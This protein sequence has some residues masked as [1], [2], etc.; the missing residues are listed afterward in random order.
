MKIPTD[1]KIVC[2]TGSVWTGSRR[3]PRHMLV[4]DGFVRPVWF[5]TAH[6][7]NDAKYQHISETEFHIAKADGK[8]LA[9]IEYGGN[10]VGI[11][12]EALEAALSASQVGSLIVGPQDLVAGV[13]AKISS[14]IIF[15]LKDASMDLSPHLEDTERRGQLHR[16]DVDA[17]APGAWGDVYQEMSR[18]LGLEGQLD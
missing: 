7:I 3:A 13:A 12:N 17:L 4:K 8:L 14:A 9:Y 11:A 2:I 1:K 16:L 18:V 6:R 15:T 5:T 10:F